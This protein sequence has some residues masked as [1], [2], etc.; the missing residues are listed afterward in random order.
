MKE[1]TKFREGTRW[2]E[3]FAMKGRKG[4]EEEEERES[5]MKGG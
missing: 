1:E 2:H 4:G 5:K 3:R